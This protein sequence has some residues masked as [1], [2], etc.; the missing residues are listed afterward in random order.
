MHR[1]LARLA[2]ASS[3]FALSTTLAAPAALAESSPAPIVRIGALSEAVMGPDGTLEHWL[4]VTARDRDGVITEITVEW[5][6]DDFSSVVFVSRPCFLLPSDPG[7]TVAMR[8]PVTLPRPG[9]YRARV[10]AHSV[11]SCGAFDE[12]TGPVRQRRFRVV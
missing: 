11:E 3:V 6:G 12:Q 2:V 4:D 9:T 7:E 10:H 8:I 5:T 1:S